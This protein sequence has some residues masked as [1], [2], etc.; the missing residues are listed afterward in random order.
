[1]H[2]TC[3]S[4][5]V[6]I[7]ICADGLLGLPLYV[8]FIIFNFSNSFVSVRL[9][10]MADLALWASTLFAQHNTFSLVTSAFS[11][12]WSSY[13]IISANMSVSFSP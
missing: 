4:V 9:L 11:S 5:F 2:N 7:F 3:V 6:D 1:M 10:I 8:A 12:V 13:I